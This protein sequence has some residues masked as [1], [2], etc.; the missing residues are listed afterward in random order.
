MG[1]YKLR[2][3]LPTVNVWVISPTATMAR[4]YL[5]KIHTRGGFLP[6]EK[7]HVINCGTAVRGVRIDPNWDI[8]K[9]VA[10]DLF[11]NRAWQE[12]R[13]AFNPAFV[14][15]RDLDDYVGSSR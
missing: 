7:V 15:F 4:Y 10:R 12:M 9:V 13:E 6:N 5:D 2:L 1:R 11:T 3:K 8:I 14:P